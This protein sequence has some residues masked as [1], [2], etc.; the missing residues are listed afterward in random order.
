MSLPEELT[1]VVVG[2]TKM[3]SVWEALGCFLSE[4]SCDPTCVL[5]FLVPVLNS[6]C[7][8]LGKSRGAVR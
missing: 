7:M 4:L 5:P 6:E 3:A 8:T 1:C 2:G